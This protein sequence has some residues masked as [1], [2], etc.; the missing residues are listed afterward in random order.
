LNQPLDEGPAVKNQQAAIDIADLRASARRHVEQGTVTESYRANRHGVAAEF[1][2]DAL[3]GERHAAW[4]AA[5]RRLLET[6]G[7]VEEVHAWDSVSLIP[8]AANGA[9]PVIATAAA[10]ALSALSA[11]LANG[12][13]HTGLVKG[14]VKEPGEHKHRPVREPGR[15][16]P[17]VEEPDPNSDPDS[18][19]TSPPDDGDRSPGDAQ[20]EAWPLRTGT[21]PRTMT[22]TLTI[23]SARL[24]IPEREPLTPPPMPAPRPPQPPERPPRPVPGDPIPPL[25]PPPMP[26]PGRPTPAPTP[27]PPQAPPQ[28]PPLRLEFCMKQAGRSRM[29]GAPA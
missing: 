1:L 16:P 22:S 13:A 7:A 19:P 28:A 14:P 17:P 5:R 8:G 29:H 23:L 15:P 3:E 24:H 25:V 11:L 2:E 4:L 9:G 18:D 12:V 26:D 21:G 27:A 6:I 10:L 20:A